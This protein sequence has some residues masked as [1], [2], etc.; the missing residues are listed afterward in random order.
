MKTNYKTRGLL[1]LLYKRK[2][3][4]I[5]SHKIFSSISITFYYLKN[6][7]ANFLTAKTNFSTAAN[8]LENEQKQNKKKIRINRA[9]LEG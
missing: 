2:V 4:D 1:L 5:E 9:H 3:I 6:Q 7:K 8:Y